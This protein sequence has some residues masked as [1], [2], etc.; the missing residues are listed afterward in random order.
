M[1]DLMWH[2]PEITRSRHAVAAL[3]R[4]FRQPV[5]TRTGFARRAGIPEHVAR[6]LLRK[7]RADGVVEVLRAASGRRVAIL[8]FAE[9]LDMAEG[10]AAG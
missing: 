7:L 1:D 10:R 8:V 9:L 4:L 5:F 3:D 6:R 2:L